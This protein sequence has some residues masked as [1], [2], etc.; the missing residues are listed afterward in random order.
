MENS[1]LKHITKEA[2]ITWLSSITNAENLFQ[3]YFELNKKNIPLVE[4]YKTIDKN[5]SKSIG[6]EANTNL[7]SINQGYTQLKETSQFFE[8]DWFYPFS[9][10]SIHKHLRY[11]PIFWHEHAFFEMCYVISGKCTHVLRTLNKSIQLNL[12]TGD[13]L[14]IPPGI[15][16]NITMNSNSIVVNILLR[17][18]TFEKVFLNNL[19]SE[20]IL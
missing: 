10:V 7:R 6:I 1:S 14:I 17:K 12:T 2:I 19:P 3:S 9:D 20:T 16:H 15:E 4:M 18:S 8:T 5:L 13:L 11:F